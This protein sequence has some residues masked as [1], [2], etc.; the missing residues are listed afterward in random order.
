MPGQKSLTVHI[1][2]CNGPDFWFETREADIFLCFSFKH[3][4]YKQLGKFEARDTINVAR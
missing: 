4:V 1:S 2:A 3:Q